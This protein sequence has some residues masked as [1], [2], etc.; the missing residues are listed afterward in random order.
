MLFAER[1]A[2]W[3]PDL[4]TFE[5]RIAEAEPLS[6]Y[7]ACLEVLRGK[8]GKHSS[9]EDEPIHKLVQFVSTEIHTLQDLKKWPALMPT[10]DDIL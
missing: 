7:C 1:R 2:K 5:S 3:E 9:R 8:F 6:L 10:I 4:S